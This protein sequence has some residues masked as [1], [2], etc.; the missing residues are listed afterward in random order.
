M[1]IVLK[2]IFSS[3][4]TE[5]N[6]SWGMIYVLELHMVEGGVQQKEAF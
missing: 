1:V 5:G 6:V 4:S 2:N 3:L